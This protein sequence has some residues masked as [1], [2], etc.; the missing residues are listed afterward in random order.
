MPGPESSVDKTRHG[1]RNLMQ[2]GLHGHRDGLVGGDESVCG[3]WALC[4]SLSEPV[5]RI[6]SQLRL[7][8][9]ALTRI[10]GRMTRW[11]CERLVG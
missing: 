8:L 9:L 1:V 3:G 11:G 6:T 2:V 5:V 4:C 10:E 7:E